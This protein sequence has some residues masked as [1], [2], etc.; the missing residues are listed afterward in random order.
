[1]SAAL[2]KSTN[3]RTVPKSRQKTVTGIGSPN[4]LHAPR[5]RQTRFVRGFLLAMA[6]R[7]GDLVRGAGMRAVGL[8]TCHRPV[9]L[10]GRGVSG[11]AEHDTMDPY[12]G[13]A[14]TRTPTPTIKTPFDLA[15]SLEFAQMTCAQARETL[16]FLIEAPVDDPAGPYQASVCLVQLALERVE[17]HLGAMIAQAM[18]DAAQAQSQAQKAGAA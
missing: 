14:R 3:A 2:T 8:P 11:S 15:L 6:G 13:A 18:A 4:G 7:W 16:N 1:M 5:P 9:T 12:A 17:E 10:F